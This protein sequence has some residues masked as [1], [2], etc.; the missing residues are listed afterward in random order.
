M[1]SSTCNASTVKTAAR[2]DMAVRSRC[3]PRRFST[4]SALSLVVV[5]IWHHRC[6]VATSLF[7]S[8]T[9][10]PRPC[11]FQV[12]LEDGSCL[13]AK[14]VVCAMGPGPMFAGMRATLPWWAEDLAA[15]LAVAPTSPTTRLQHSSQL[16][17][18]LRRLT[19]TAY[20]APSASSSWAVAR[21]PRTSPCS[22]IKSLNAS[23]HARG[24]ESR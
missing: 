23:S 22:P 2:A 4:A 6:A 10:G 8:L 16:T 20:S 12:H 21:R 5:T 3:R 13:A 24:G 9:A 19:E 17:S 7:A 1:S 15:E 11:T 18:W 14:R